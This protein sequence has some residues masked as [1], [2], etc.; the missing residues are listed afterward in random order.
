VQRARRRTVTD[1]LPEILREHT[2]YIQKPAAV[3]KFLEDRTVGGGDGFRC[4]GVAGVVFWEIIAAE[5]EV[6]A[7]EEANRG[8]GVVVPG[9]GALVGVSI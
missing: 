9:V 3:F 4:G 1:Q 5:P 7:D 6:E 2:P 8:V